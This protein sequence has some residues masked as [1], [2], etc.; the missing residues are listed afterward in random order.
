MPNGPKGQKRPADVIANAIHVMRT[1]TLD[2]TETPTDDG[3]NATAV[4]LARKG[5]LARAKATTKRERQPNQ[6]ALR[7]SQQQIAFGTGDDLRELEP[8]RLSVHRVRDLDAG[9]WPFDSPN[10]LSTLEGF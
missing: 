6:A 3:K 4:A 9:T 1:A 5:R 10:R 2:V 7:E 8:H